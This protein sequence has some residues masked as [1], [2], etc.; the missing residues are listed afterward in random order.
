MT[1]AQHPI[2]TVFLNGLDPVPGVPGA[3]FSNTGVGTPRIDSG[4]LVSFA[5]GT[6]G[7]STTGVWTEST[8]GLNGALS[9]LAIQGG[10]VPGVP[11]GTFPAL[12]GVRFVMSDNGRVAFPS[13]VLGA[14]G[15]N[16]I[17]SQEGPGLALVGL[18]GQIAP[19]SP[20]GLWNPASDTPLAMSPNGRVAFNTQFAVGNGNY[21]A[22]FYGV[23]SGVLMCARTELDLAKPGFTSF[24]TPDFNNN[25]NYG[26]GANYRNND[27]TRSY[28]FS[29]TC[30]SL[31]VVVGQ[32]ATIPAYVGLPE[33]ETFVGPF[34][35]D[36]NGN[37]EFA[38]TS[39]LNGSDVNGSNGTSLWIKTNSGFRMIARQ[40]SQVP[41]LPTGV[42]YGE[43]SAAASFVGP[44]Y[45]KSGHVLF[46]VGLRGPAVSSD[47]NVAILRYNPDGTI[48]TIARLGSPVP[49]YPAGATY[50][51]FGNG[52][53]AI[54]DWGQVCFAAF[55]S[56]AGA[57][58]GA[59]PIMASDLTGGVRIL[60]EPGSTFALRPGLQ[61]R[62]N[63]ATEPLPSGGTDGRPRNWNKS[64]QFAFRG[65]YTIT[66]GG[67]GTGFGV[68]VIGLPD[69]P[70]DI[71]HDGFVDDADFSIFS[72]AYDILLC[73]DPAMP[74]DCP[75]DLNHDSF[76][77]DQDFSIFVLG[78]DALICP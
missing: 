26:V 32:G 48:T 52:G 11:G 7:V 34:T 2:R 78:Y 66:S 44:L 14:G 64:A 71:N 8:P 28:I 75:A 4:G 38:F 47:N 5:T 46:R 43:F 23:P 42:N 51:G 57:G 36:M 54:N 60:L 15:P 21:N 50:G 33:F 35:F 58:R 18:Q 70:G 12:S 10:P 77:D 49:G 68:F 17:W 39:G 72:P 67:A 20:P 31:Q 13:A 24:G 53:L 22:L 1:F 61:G 45:S 29:G 9:L 62:I 74:E 73:S 56:N 41:S 65:G 55:V 16:G 30:A 69:C 6:S 76:V 19:V 27:G 37:N 63:S 59:F 3:S 25:F 40:G